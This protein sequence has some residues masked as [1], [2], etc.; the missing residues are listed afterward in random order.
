ML[1]S[2]FEDRY[3]GVYYKVSF[4]THENGWT[5]KLDIDELPLISDDDHLWKS[6]EEAHQAARKIAEDMI[7]R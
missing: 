4:Y 6:K 7:G 3:Q 5:F 1:Q 2:A